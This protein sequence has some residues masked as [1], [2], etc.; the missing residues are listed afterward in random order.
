MKKFDWNHPV[1]RKDC[2]VLC[3][4]VFGISMV[5]YIVMIVVAY[6]EDIKTLVK[7]K[8]EKIKSKPPWCG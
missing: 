4:W 6:W 3:G 8:I 2:A 5:M 1:T 7:E